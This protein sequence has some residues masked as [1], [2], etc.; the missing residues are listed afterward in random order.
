[1]HI[2]CKFFTTET[3]VTVRQTRKLSAKK[4]TFFTR[5]I[6]KSTRR[7][8]IFCIFFTEICISVDEFPSYF[9]SFPPFFFAR[10]L[11]LVFH[12]AEDRPRFQRSI[13]I[14]PNFCRAIFN[15]ASSQLKFLS[16][17]L[18]LHILNISCVL[19]HEETPL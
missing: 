1:M 16:N 15:N 4:S 13:I 3:Y 17:P 7:E 14:A 9:S 5:I 2:Y 10:V 6:N 8:S 18:A 19:T 11:S 12:N